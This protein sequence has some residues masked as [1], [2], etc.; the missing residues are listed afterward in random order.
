[1]TFKK[2]MGLSFVWIAALALALSA[3]GG[4]SSSSSSSS[5]TTT[6][7]STA[8]DCSAPTKSD[9]DGC[10]YVD[11]TDAP[12]D[13]LTY[14]VDVTALTL[15]RADG[16]VVNV[17]PQTTTVDFAQY[18]DLD[19]FL[20]LADMPLGTYTSGT[21]T[22]DYSSADIEVQDSSGNAVKVSPVDANGKPITSLSLQIQLSNTGELILVPGVP[23]VLQLDFNLAASNVV[24]LT[25]DT[26]TVQPFLVASVNPDLDNQIRVRGPLGSVDTGTSS[27]KLGLR[28]FDAGSG[29]FGDMG[30]LT[31]SSTVFNIN[32][33]PY[34]GSAGLAALAAAGATT[35]VVAKGSFDFSTHRF[36]AAEVDA[37][38][39]VLGGTLDAAEGVVLSRNGNAI[40]LRGATLYRAGQTASFHDDVSVTLGSGTLVH[41]EGSPNKTFSIADISVGQRLRVFGTLTDTNPS[42]LALDATKGY[43][44]LRYTRFDGTVVT[45]PNGSGSSITMAVDVQYME[46]RPVSLFDFTGTGSTP[47]NYVVSMPVMIDGI[48]VND[49]VRLWGFVTPFGSAPPDFTETSVAD[50]VDARSN[51][52]VAWSQPGTADAFSA[53]SPGG[54]M[55][56]NTATSPAPSLARV[57][58]GGIETS[59]PTSPTV[60]GS[61]G[62][63]A[64]LQDGVVTV[65]LSYS[66]FI[67]DLTS[68]LNAG[69]KVDLVFARGGYDSTDSTMQAADTAVVL[70]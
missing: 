22:L 1:M 36:V 2:K 31:T 25:G 4:G 49:P 41:E 35:A 61:V 47:T 26:V 17:L 55:V 21:I 65:H 70:Q 37:G 18:S 3:C 10:A 13:F 34:Q 12:G 33:T 11:M 68:R 14:T 8:T 50:Y 9:T 40:V 51:L 19:E 67:S 59:V 56:V 16:T 53:L 43:A 5:G 52:T 39:S 54:G 15:K 32:Q 60:K 46:G 38:S 48:A 69:A 29:D 24:D 27:F 63:F 64:I 20:S 6:P 23:K 45:A 28:P 44:S 42:A 7:V 57:G 58:Q 62:I 30:I 66:T